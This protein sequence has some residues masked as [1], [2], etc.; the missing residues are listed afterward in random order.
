MRSP[1]LNVNE[2]GSSEMGAKKSA[3]VQQEPQEPT[4][5]ERIAENLHR[6]G[7]AMKAAKAGWNTEA[8]TPDM[9]DAMG[10]YLYGS[11]AVDPQFAISTI[12]EA[13]QLAT[14]IFGSDDDVDDVI[15]IADILLE[16][17]E[18]KE[19][20]SESS[21]DA[22]RLFGAEGAQYALWFY[23]AVYAGPFGEAD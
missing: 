2:N 11:D 1:E 20:L 17:E 21:E 23:Y 9:V 4:E 3:K 12:E 8:P 22:A 14:K 6:I 7:E 10:T 18:A 16:D 13:R 5:E 15:A 19:R